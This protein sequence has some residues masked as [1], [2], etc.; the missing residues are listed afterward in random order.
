MANMEA[1]WEQGCN[2]SAFQ[3]YSNKGHIK[4]A[5]FCNYFNQFKAEIYLFSSQAEHYSVL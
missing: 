1:L 4:K 2:G 5:F 3:R